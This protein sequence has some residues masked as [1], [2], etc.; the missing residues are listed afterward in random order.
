MRVIAYASLNG[1]Q[2][3]KA[4]AVKALSDVFAAAETNLTPE[5]ILKAVADYYN[6]KLEEIRGAGR[7]KEV[8]IPRQMAMYL[9]REMT[10]ASLPEIGQ[11]FDGRDHT[12]VLY[13][14]QKIQESVDSDP[15]LQQALKG[16]KERL[17]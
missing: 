2:L 14:I 11:F 3:S 8:V 15:A 1:V 16:I 5:E 17:R 12:T 13:A 9:I 6:L 4:V 7:R 10:H